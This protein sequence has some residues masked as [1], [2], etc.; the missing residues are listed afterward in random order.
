VIF[1]ETELVGAFVIDLECHVDERGF[2]AR[3]FCE[4]E[5]AAVGLEQNWVQWNIS[6]NRHKGTL[7]GLHY[8]VSPHAEAKLVR[9]TSGALY[10][11]IVDMR[12]GSPTWLRWKG[13]LLDAHTHRMLYVPEGFA[14]GFITLA[15]ETEVFYQMSAPYLAEAARGARWNDPSLEIHWPIPP[16]V[17]STRDASYPDLDLTRLVELDS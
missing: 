8:Q 6:W 13:V 14:H 1:E 5:F 4:D 2:F 12:P 15:D 3:S 17:M 16:E 11:V 9:C 10:D 7:R